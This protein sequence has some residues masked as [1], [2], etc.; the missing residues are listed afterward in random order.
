MLT[1]AFP[2]GLLGGS[3]DSEQLPCFLAQS[4]NTIRR[5]GSGFGQQFEPKNGLVRLFDDDSQF[6]NELSM[7]SRAL[8]SPTVSGNRGRGTEQLFSDDLGVRAIGQ[9]SE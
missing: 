4:S 6:R 2:D 3:E 5:D 1:V 7:R 9:R 8:R